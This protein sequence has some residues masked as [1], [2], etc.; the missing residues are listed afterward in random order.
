M[1]IALWIAQVILGIKMLTAAFSHGLLHGKPEIQQAIQVV[2]KQAKLLLFLASSFMVL[3]IGGLFLPA[4]VQLPLW[5]TPAAAS[6]LSL[7]LLVSIYFHLVARDTPNV[8]VSVILFLIGAFV[9]YGRFLLV[10]L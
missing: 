2:G 10:P 8:F 5:V 1:N 3:G 6:M 9:A 7:M 4:L